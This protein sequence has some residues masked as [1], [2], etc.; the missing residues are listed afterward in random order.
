MNDGADQ[1]LWQSIVAVLSACL[2]IVLG[3][4]HIQHRAEVAD[5]K[6]DTAA[7][8]KA[9]DEAKQS[10]VQVAFEAGQALAEHKLYA[11]EN[12]SRKDELKEQ[13]K[14]LEERISARIDDV[15]ELVKKH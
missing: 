2:S 12:F 5:M 9:A 4:L 7:A 15:I 3:W 6:A 1:S 14:Q 11:A 10:A 13:F 8:Q